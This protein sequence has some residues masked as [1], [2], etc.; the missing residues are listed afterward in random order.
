MSPYRGSKKPN[1]MGSYTRT[2]EEDKAM[3]WCIQNNI[4]IAP[5]QIKWGEALWVIDIETGIYPNRKLIGT[6]EPFGPVEIWKKVAEYCKYYYDKHEN[7]IQ[8]RK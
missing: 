4:C 5:R 7:N 8:K 2:D 6:S 3:I 1:M